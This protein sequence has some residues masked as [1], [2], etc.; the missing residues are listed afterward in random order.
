MT[1]TAIDNAKITSEI[2]AESGIH[3]DKPPQAPPPPASAAHEQ[4]ASLSVQD[5]TRMEERESQT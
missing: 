2:E 3:P 4:P 1:T 5:E